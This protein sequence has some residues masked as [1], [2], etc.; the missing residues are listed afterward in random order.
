MITRVDKSIAEYE[1]YNKIPVGKT[2]H[3]V[4]VPV[5]KDVNITYIRFLD[6]QIMV[7]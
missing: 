6:R 4:Q 2:R 1:E 3:T 5:S 7:K